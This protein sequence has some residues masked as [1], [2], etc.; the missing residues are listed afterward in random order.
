RASFV[1]T[2]PELVIVDEAHTAAHG[3]GG[4]GQQQRHAL[5][6]ELAADPQRH[7]ILVTATPHSGDESAFA[8]LIGL[9]VPEL[10]ATVAQLAYGAGT[11]ARARLAH[12][13]V[14]RRRADIT[15][16]LKARTDFPTRET[17]EVPYHLTPEY[18][19]LLDATR[20]YTQELVQTAQGLSVFHQRVRWWAALALLRCVGSS[21]AAA[22]AALRTRASE[23]QGLDPKEADRLGQDA[24][25][26][27]VAVDEAEGDDG[28]PAAD[29]T[30]EGPDDGTSPERRRLLSLARQAES[31]LGER[32]PKLAKAAQLIKELLDDGFHPIV[33]CRYVATAHFVAE[34]LGRRLPRVRVQA[35]TGELPA[36]ERADRVSDLGQAEQRVLVATDC[37][38]EGINLQ[39]HFDAV[40]HYDLSWNPTRHEQREGRVDRYGQPR[41]VVRTALVYGQDNQVDG[42]VLK[43]LLRKAE[44]I[45]RTL[46]VSVPVP[47][48]TNAVLEAI[49]EALF[50]RPTHAP[51]AQL[52]L[53]FDQEEALVNR[54]WEAAADRETRN[55]TVFAQHGLHPEEVAAE[56][57]AAAS[58][59][60]TSADVRR[61]IVESCARLAVP[62]IPDGRVLKLDARLLPRAVVSRAGLADDELDLRLGF[63]LPVPEKVTY[64]PRTH[65]LVEALAGYVLDTALDEPET[66]IA[67]R[68]AAIRTGEVSVRTVL[69]LLRAR[70]LIEAIRDERVDPMLAEECLMAGFSGDP[71]EPTWLDRST[72]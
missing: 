56:Q 47:V 48:D 42:I 11:E 5:L 60:G 29:T 51:A 59:V 66:A 40:V 1:Q 69:L 24:V 22:A 67:R 36:E 43:V 3:Q 65:P 68:G 46:G 31:L 72:V 49:F 39:Q 9:L 53:F 55:R 12:H 50:L 16:Y 27:L 71:R 34:E 58:A 17:Q 26:D 19:K 38:S 61:L 44:A 25:F 28:T 41:P 54:A 37:L 8:S 20:E 2:C 30:A 13:V 64:V 52:S 32:D 10:E 15:E 21:P 6:Q 45:R 35:V 14:Q 23:S 4:A 7:L 57:Q 70:Y 63:E 62:A 18:R 33:F